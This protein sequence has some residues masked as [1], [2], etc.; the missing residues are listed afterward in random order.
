MSSALDKIDPISMP[1]IAPAIAAGSGLLGLA[2]SEDADAGLMHK[3]A[4]DAAR[5]FAKRT[6]GDGKAPEMKER[7]REAVIEALEEMR[8]IGNRMRQQRRDGRAI[9]NALET[10]FAKNVVHP[11]TTYDT[12]N[13]AAREVDGGHNGSIF[14]NGMDIFYEEA[15]E[16]MPKDMRHR[17][18][19]E[20]TLK[21]WTRYRQR[22][23]KGRSRLGEQDISGSQSDSKAWDDQGEYLAKAAQMPDALQRANRPQRF[24]HNASKRPIVKKKDEFFIDPKTGRKKKKGPVSFAIGG[25][26]V[27]DDHLQATMHNRDQKIN[28]HMD[29]LGLTKDSM[30]DYGSLLPV[31]TNVVTGERSMAAPDMVRDVVKGLLG[32]GMT[33]KTGIYDPQNLMD[34]V[35]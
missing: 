25:P 15:L 28:E 21:G 1:K 34:T 23:G 16:A 6:A 24:R 9:R 11:H 10:H 2:L 5:A 22:D 3:T 17:G 8:G 26:S 27:S 12:F 19:Y 18:L 35:L 4:A 13:R 30:Y 7:Y 29:N 33:A 31:K 32:L 14:L 20:D